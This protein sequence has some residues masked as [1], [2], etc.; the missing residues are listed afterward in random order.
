MDIAQINSQTQAAFSANSSPGSTSLG[1]Q[2]FLQLLV[3]QLQ[4]QDP[5]SPLDSAEY[6]AQLAQFSSVEQLVNINDGMNAMVQSQQLMSNGLNNTMAAS[7]AGKTVSA[8]SDRVHIEAGNAADINFR[9]NGIASNVDV[10]ILDANGNVVRSEE[11]SGFGKGDHTWSWDG[12]TDSGT[13][14]PGGVY[15]V[16][17]TASNGDNPVDV[18]TFIEGTVDRIKYTGNG[19]ELIVDGVNIPLGD[20][21]EIGT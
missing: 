18:L 10:K 13:T 4:N 19:V 8:L 7:L 15:Q 20:V 6:A 11:L 17:F 21:E 14:A 3:T 1:Q 16:E 12:K 5:L 2:E 9:L